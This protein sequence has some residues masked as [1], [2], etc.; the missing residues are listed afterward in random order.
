M[1][2]MFAL[3]DCNNFYDSCEFVV[4]FAVSCAETLRHQNSP[5]NAV[6]IFFHTNGFRKDLPQYYRNI[7]IKTETPT[8]S[9]FDLIK[10]AY[11]ALDCI[12]IKDF[13]HKKVGVIVMNLMPENQKQ[14]SLFSNDNPKHQP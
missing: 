10:A 14:F 8:N 6:M 13:H 3:V 4:T 11:K 7:I 12:Y 2:L 1:L 9:N 5:T